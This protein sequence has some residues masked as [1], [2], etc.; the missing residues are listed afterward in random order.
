MANFIYC[1]VILPAIVVT[2]FVS[3]IHG[4]N[5]NFTKLESTII[6]ESQWIETV[7]KYIT[8]EEHRLSQL[9][10]TIDGL[11]QY[12]QLAVND[13]DAY[14]SHP[15]NIYLLIK[16]LATEWPQVDKLLDQPTH[17]KLRLRVNPIENNDLTEA[18]KGLQNLVNTYQL[19]IQALANGSV[20]FWSESESR[21]IT[22]QPS[23]D[24]HRLT[25]ADCYLIGKQALISG[26]NQSAKQWFDETIK[27][28]VIDNTTDNKLF[29]S[30]VAKHM[31]LAYYRLGD[32]NQSVYYMNKSNE[33]VDYQSDTDILFNQL[34]AE[35]IITN[36]SNNYEEIN[37]LSDKQQQQQPNGSQHQDLDKYFIDISKQL[38]RGLKRMNR[39]VES[40]LRCR[41]LNTTNRPLLRLT[42]VKVEQLYDK[43]EIVVFHDI[44][45]HREIDVMKQL[46]AKRLSRLFVLKNKTKTLSSSRVADGSWLRDRDHPV[47]ARL[48]RRIGAIIG[49]N[50]YGTESYNVIKYAV[51]GYYSNH[52][53]VVVK[54]PYVGDD[55]YGL[56]YDRLGTWITYL[57]DVQAGGATVFP[58]LNVRVEPQKGS[59]LFWYNLRSSGLVDW[60]MLHSGCPVLV[61][62][63]KW[64]ATKWIRFTKQEF[65]KPCLLDKQLFNYVN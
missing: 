16:R 65:H 23:D 22:F 49:V 39:S 3:L 47:V 28:T 61:G 31:A 62:G 45:D 43:P 56:P 12:N 44:L 57:S 58:R 17:N 51:G 10:S 26:H 20:Q 42:R 36:K 55:Q 30:T 59:A 46:A 4:F 21:D 15:I 11:K 5:I 18:A 7:E 24:T 35:L 6:E 38:C 33:L 40:R 48:T 8:D 52:Y 25:A 27:R 34:F 53:D 37:Q 64:I 19:D 63:P 54:K 9:K 32:Y 1:L 2:L 29:Q 13:S 14:L 41:Y 60:D 50:I